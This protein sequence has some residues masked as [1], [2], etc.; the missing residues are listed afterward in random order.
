MTRQ[1]KLIEMIQ[2]IAELINDNK[3]E[4]AQAKGAEVFISLAMNPNMGDNEFDVVYQMYKNT[5]AACLE[6]A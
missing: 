6:T 2:G 1:E 4:P 3:I 5:R